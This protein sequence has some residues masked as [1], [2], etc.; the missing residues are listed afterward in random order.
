M[1]RLIAPRFGPNVAPD[2]APG[3]NREGGSGTLGL[4]IAIGLVVWAGVVLCATSSWSA[5]AQTTAPKGDATRLEWPLP[6]EAAS[7]DHVPT[8]D[9]GPGGQTAPEAGTIRGAA[10]VIGRIAPLPPLRAV[11][12]A[13][14]TTSAEM[15]V[16]DA[17]VARSENEVRRARR[18][19]MEGISLRLSAWN[20]SVQNRLSSDDAPVV[21]P[22]TALIPTGPAIERRLEVGIEV[23]LYDLFGRSASVGVFTSRL[24]AAERQRAVI[25]DRAR[26]NAIDRYYEAQ[27]WRDLT[28]IQSEA[29]TATEAHLQQARAS[30]QQGTTSI[31]AVSRQIEVAAKARARFAKA[32]SQYEQA[33]RQLQRLIG[34]P[35][36]TLIPAAAEAGSS[37]SRSASPVAPRSP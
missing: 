35:L 34:A 36:R 19:W 1:L 33:R 17:L 31:N 30:F 15:G 20:G 5:H 18:S 11:V 2:A 14:E 4:R 16:Q 12:A 13:A 32:R 7:G 9:L 29:L 25:R 10:D 37:A 6:T 23:S 3:F 27:R 21:E 22:L 28:V 24:H 8:E 26:R